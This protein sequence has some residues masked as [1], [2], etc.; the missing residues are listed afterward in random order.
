M[1]RIISL[2]IFYITKI[3][4]VCLNSKIHIIRDMKAFIIQSNTL[5]NL[6]ECPNMS[7][8]FLEK[9]GIIDINQK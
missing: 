1:K 2:N 8:S 5:K 3:D 7:I 4:K 6:I 9:H